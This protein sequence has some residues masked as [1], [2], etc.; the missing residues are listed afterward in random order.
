MN[1]TQVLLIQIAVIVLLSRLVGRL[2][3]VVGQPQ[4]VGEMIAG[5]MLG[6]SVLGLVGHGV[7]LKTLFP[8]ELMGNLEVLTQLGVILFMFIVGMELDLRL[9]KGQGKAAVGAAAAGIV[10][11]F[12]CGALLGWA[13]AAI[14][15]SQ[16]GRTPDRVVL[17]LFIAAAMSIT[18]FPVLAR[19]L[20]ESK[21]NRTPLAA[22]ALTSA[23]MVD[24]IGWCV[25]ALVLELA[26][27][28]GFGA[29]GAG[30]GFGDHTAAATIG[31][32]G[33]YIVVMF[34]VVRPMLGRLVRQF[35][36]HG[37]LTHG[38]FTV[39]F[40]FLIASSLATDAI[41][42]HPVFGAFLLG[43][44]MPRDAR[45]V[46]HITG[47][48]ED[49]T[50]LFLLPLFF[51]YTGLRTEL[52]L[53]DSWRLWM[54]CGVVVLTAVGGKL[55]G[56]SL[57]ARSFGMSWRE[58]LLLGSLMNTRGLMELIILNIGLTLGVLTASLFTMMV[59][60]AVVT[61]LMTSPLIRLL[62][63]PDLQSAARTGG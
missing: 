10:V 34:A 55:G 41:G 29:R 7:W 60:M 8:P 40:V 59:V 63:S 38:G 3:R 31:L 26:R 14:P 5:I 6:P 62:E 49:V 30:H 42:I 48:V 46:K 36:S 13:L 28:R 45:L 57:A 25:L 44:V 32:T 37:R 20:M 17:C 43:A 22:L 12:V 56:V 35:G 4:V 27:Y 39:L 2:V 52:G 54:I 1:A 19:I 61:T 18:A 51:A 16:T 47:K 11:P 21:L 9:L 53:L 23:A 58:S 24:C 50:I 33:G 15:E